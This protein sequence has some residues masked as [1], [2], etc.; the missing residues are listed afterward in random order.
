[1]ACAACGVP[2]TAAAASDYVAR[3][4]FDLP[5]PPPL[6]VTE[7]RAYSC[8]CGACGAQTPNADPKHLIAALRLA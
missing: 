8:L 2:L 7:H 4:V 3:Q 1:M 5:E 6:I